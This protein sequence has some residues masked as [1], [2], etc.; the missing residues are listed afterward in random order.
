M[1]AIPPPAGL[2]RPR[3]PAALGLSAPPPPPHFPAGTS[4]RRT[5]PARATGAPWRT[6]PCE[7]LRRCRITQWCLEPGWQEDRQACSS[8]LH[9]LPCLQPAVRQRVSDTARR[10]LCVP[11]C[12]QGGGGGGGGGGPH[13]RVPPRLCGQRAGGLRWVVGVLLSPPLL[14]CGTAWGWA[15]RTAFSL[16]QD[17]CAAA[18]RLGRAPLPLL[19]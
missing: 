6:T 1:H 17:P 13:R 4:S 16:S 7:W 9:W 10:L 15:E 19:R 2:P 3:P 11:A 12:V 5:A 8:D 14:S 18:T